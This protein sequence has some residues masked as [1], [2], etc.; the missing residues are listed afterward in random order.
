M[1]EELAVVSRLDVVSRLAV[2]S[3]LA[4]RWSAKQAPRILSEPVGG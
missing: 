3:G 4:P 1:W 2:V